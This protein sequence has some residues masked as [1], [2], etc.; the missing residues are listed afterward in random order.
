M[1]VY[2]RC[3]QISS[4]IKYIEFALF[5]DQPSTNLKTA[6]L[7]MATAQK[8]HATKQLASKPQQNRQPKVFTAKINHRVHYN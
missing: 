5:F 8:T 7:S 3:I 4:T 1:V 2:K 6:S